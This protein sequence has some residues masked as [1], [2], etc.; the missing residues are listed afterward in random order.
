MAGIFCLKY[1]TMILKLKLDEAIKL[2]K[3]L[4]DELTKLKRKI[5]DAY[6]QGQKERVDTLLSSWLSI[7]NDLVSLK[8]E[9]R[10]ANIEEDISKKIYERD[11]L[12]ILGK[13]YKNMEGYENRVNKIDEAIKR[14]SNDIT[15]CN[16]LTNIKV[17]VESESLKNIAKK[18]A[19]NEN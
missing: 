7:S 17:E 8:T 3:I 6:K 2:Q 19:D 13:I 14:L 11:E 1:L 15:V 5:F 16:N 4:T 9:I 12:K 10:R 18:R